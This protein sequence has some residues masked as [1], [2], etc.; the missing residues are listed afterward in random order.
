MVENLLK[1]KQ[2][3]QMEEMTPAEMAKAISDLTETV[4]KLKAKMQCTVC[5]GTGKQPVSA[6]SSTAPAHYCEACCCSGSRFV[7]VEWKA[8][9]AT[10]RLEKTIEG[11]EQD[12]RDL[13]TNLAYHQH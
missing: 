10:E 1:T 12:V 11:L 4:E 3:Y 2:E 7:Q 5:D 13:E 6:Y 9:V 8:T